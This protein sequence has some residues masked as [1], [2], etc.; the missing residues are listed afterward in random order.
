MKLSLIALGLIAFSP[1]L[2]A[3]SEPVPKNGNSRLIGKWTWTRPSNNCTEVY[4]FREDGTLF[5][6]SGKEKSDNTYNLS[7]QPTPAGFFT[8]TTTIVKD[9]GGKDCGDTEEDDSGGTDIRYIRFLPSGT[10]YIVCSEESL[11]RCFG[12]LHRISK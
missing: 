10:Q 2:F 9:H 6:V 3:V 4:E 5:V 1:T 12:P 7:A 11:N 8:L